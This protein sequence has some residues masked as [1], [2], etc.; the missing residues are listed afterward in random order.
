MRQRRGLNGRASVGLQPSAKKPAPPI[1][2]TGNDNLTEAFKD[3]VVLD[4]A[5][6]RVSELSLPTGV[7][8]VADPEDLVVKLAQRRV[9]AADEEEAAAAEAP[10]EGAEEAAT[11]GE[12]NSEETG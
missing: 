6:V 7:A 10:A 1:S 2:A 11:A 8:A 9:T 4:Y 12:A 3:N 5:G